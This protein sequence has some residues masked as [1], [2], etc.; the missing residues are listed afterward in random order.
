MKNLLI[1]KEKKYHYCWVKKSVLSLNDQ[2]FPIPK[3]TVSLRKP[4][5][6]P[7]DPNRI[8]TKLPNFLPGLTKKHEITSYSLPLRCK[9]DRGILDADT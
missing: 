6:K 7:M 1:L 9:G 8:T 4:N 5:L 3:R 2:N